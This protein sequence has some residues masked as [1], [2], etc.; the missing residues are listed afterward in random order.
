MSAPPARSGRGRPPGWWIPWTF[1][2]GFALVVAV[3]GALVVV[4]IRSWTGLVTERP[5]DRGLDYNRNLEA[6]AAMAGLGWTARLVAGPGPAGDHELTL[7]VRDRTGAPVSGL[8]V[9]GTLER[10]LAAGQDRAL[11]LDP[12]G[13]GLY[14]TRLELPAGGQWHARLRLVRGAERMVLSERLVL[15]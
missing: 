9:L 3:N 10:P 7:E 12:A 5:Y 14:R 2:A 1:V 4:A 15:R 8:A 13:P 11:A 6:A